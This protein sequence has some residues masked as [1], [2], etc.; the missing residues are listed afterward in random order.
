[1]ETPDSIKIGTCA[2][3]FDDWRGVF[4][5]AHLPSGGRLEFSARHL[6]AV[7]IDATFYHAPA[8]HV[9]AHWCE[10]TPHDFVFTAKMPRE[11]THERKLRD[12]FE[13]VVAFLASIEALRRKLA[14]ILIQLPPWFSPRMV[15]S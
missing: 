2:W 4:Y 3:S 10:V 5:P 12:S 14:C 9:A 7:E 15:G 6:P 11:I 13:Q 1:M 8:E